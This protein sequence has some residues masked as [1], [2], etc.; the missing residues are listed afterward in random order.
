[1][2]GTVLE[3]LFAVYGTVESCKVAIDGSGRSRGFGFV[4]MDSEE[5]AQ[6]AIKALNGVILPGSSKKLLAFLFFMFSLV[7]IVPPCNVTSF[8]LWNDLSLVFLFL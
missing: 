3:D 2:S 5:A 6:L 4:Q 1:M 8:F 7:S